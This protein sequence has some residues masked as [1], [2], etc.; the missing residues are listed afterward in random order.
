MSQPIKE[1]YSEYNTATNS[2]SFKHFINLPPNT[3][4]N[5]N[6]DKRKQIIL[7]SL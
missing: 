5:F 3:I 4:P 7:N 1:V 2:S 6:L